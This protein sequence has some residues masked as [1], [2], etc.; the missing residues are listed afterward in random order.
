MV[1]AID[2][3]LQEIGCYKIDGWCKRWVVARDGL[4]QDRWL[5]QEMGCY[6]MYGLLQEMGCYKIDGL[7]QKIGCCKV[8]LAEHRGLVKVYKEM[9]VTCC[10]AGLFHT[11]FNQALHPHLLVLTGLEFLEPGRVLPAN[12][13]SYPGYQTY[14]YSNRNQRYRHRYRRDALCRN[15]FCSHLEVKSKGRDVE[16]KVEGYSIE[17]KDKDGCPNGTV[18]HPKQPGLCLGGIFL[19]FLN[20]F[21]CLPWISIASCKDTFVLLHWLK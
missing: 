16:V 21:L 15:G 10:R 17:V 4:L 6:K 9:K 14:R 18:P 1:V 20:N 11:C 3:L 13:N 12:G 8:R 5:L 2:G 19:F 7:L